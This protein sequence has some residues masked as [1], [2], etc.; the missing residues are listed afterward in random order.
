MAKLYKLDGGLIFDEPFLSLKE[1]VE[2]HKDDLTNANLRDADLFGARL[3]GFNLRGANLD[4][5][6]LTGANLR[7]ANLKDAILTNANLEGT[8]LD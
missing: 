1:A 7:G 3:K 2:K 4:G 8:I 6:I 5:A